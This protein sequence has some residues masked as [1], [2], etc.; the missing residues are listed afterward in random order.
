MLVKFF[1]KFC[2]IEFDTIYGLKPIEGSNRLILGQK[3]VEVREND[4]YLNMHFRFD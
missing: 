4:I 3:E 1:E 2:E